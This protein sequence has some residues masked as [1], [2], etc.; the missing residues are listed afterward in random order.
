MIASLP[1][2]DRP[3]TRAATDQL[4]QLVRAELNDGPETLN[5]DTDLWA[6]WQSPD[7]VLS[8]TCGM[9]YR[10]RLRAR[11]ALVGTPDFALK[12]CP[13]GYY[14]SIFVVRRDAQGDKL[15][16]FA[17]QRF[18]YNEALSQS[19]WAAPVNYAEAQ[20]LRF[21]R[22]VHSGGHT[23]SAR[24][25]AQGRA[26]IA[27]LDAQSWRLMQRHD[28][29]A[30]RLRVLCA[31]WPTPGLPCIT[32][33]TRDPAPIRNALRRAI[34]ALDDETRAALCL[35]TLV[36]IPGAAYMAVP[37]AGAPTTGHACE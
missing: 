30:E 16:D 34:A 17:T 36:D 18:A 3:E 23:A 13:P 31:T 24:A 10:T 33:I 21:S 8:Q 25:V 14:R 4:W 29:F 7:L 28:A 27:A 12:G 9:P 11:V 1:M 32:A 15:G 2:Y 19:G 35:N 6:D 20:G 22:L 37:T 5:R 26:D